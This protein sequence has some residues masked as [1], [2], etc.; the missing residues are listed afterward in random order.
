MK[1]LMNCFE[2]LIFSHVQ[3]IFRSIGK[4]KE[5]GN[6]RKAKLTY[7]LKVVSATFLLVCVYV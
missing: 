7:K 2:N 6:L 3:Y 5:K 1:N 4:R